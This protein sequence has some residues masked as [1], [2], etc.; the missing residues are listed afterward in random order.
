MGLEVSI[1]DL[2]NLPGV[3]QKWRQVHSG[4]QS[5]CHLKSACPWGGAAF[6]ISLKS[7]SATQAFGKCAACGE[8]SVNA[9]E[10]DRKA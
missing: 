9:Y 1:G 6:L 7:L 8:D 3:S 4:P 5:R 2:F 10:E